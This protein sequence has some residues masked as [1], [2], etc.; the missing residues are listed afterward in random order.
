MQEGLITTGLAFIEGFALIISP[1][2]LPILPIILSG[3]LTGSKSRP[4]G[5]V[6]GFIITFALFTLFSR[7]LIQYTTINMNMLRNISFAILLLLG[8]IMMSGRLTETLNR[9]TQGLSNVGN[10]L[11]GINRA[12]G[13]FWSGVL[14]GGLVGIIWTPC[15]GPILA[16]VIVQV[17][18]QKTTVN[19][20]LVVLAFAM[21]AGIPMLVIA[22]LGRGIMSQFVFF[23]HRASFF[24]KLLGFIIVLTVLYFWI[25]QQFAISFNQNRGVSL[26]RVNSLIN[27][28]EQAYQAPEITGI[29]AWINSPPLTWNDL[30]GKVVLVDFWTYSC[31]NCIRTL[32]YLK[33]WYE[34]YHD[35]GF[36]IIGV[37]SPEFQFEHDANNVREAVKSYGIHY[38]VALDNDFATWRNFQNEYWPAHYLVN[39]EGKVVYVHFGEGEYEVTENNIRFLLGMNKTAA[40]NRTDENY[41]LNLTPETYLGYHR[42]ERFKSP[43][44]MKKDALALYDYPAKLSEDEWA[45]SGSWL[46]SAEKIES[47]SANAAIKLHFRGSKVY[48]VMGMTKKPVTVKFLL[49]GKPLTA[50]QGKDVK[51]SELR[52]NQNRLY[53]VVHL[54]TGDEG[55]LE[56]IAKDPGLAVYTFTFG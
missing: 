14:F 17:V 19:G 27:G 47:L 13:G 30:K 42:E 38:P 2:I 16:A 11:P 54:T 44:G 23:R 26:T 18:L 12:E 34:K 8:I 24:R 22:L 37:H 9:L 43:S 56:I 39:K 3:S 20:M 10:S 50:D 6:T 36:E 33:D 7:V 35:K 28:I 1:C 55:I 51:N 52:V 5:I 31:I 49:N 46:I 15:A 40:E 32:P 21:G 41:S 53:S 25:F 45:L 48:M 4:L 29:A